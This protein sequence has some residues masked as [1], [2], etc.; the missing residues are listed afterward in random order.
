MDPKKRKRIDESVARWIETDPNMQRLK[1]RIEYYRARIEEK[2]RCEREQG[3]V[4][5]GD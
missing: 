3:S 5:G 2:E 4:E 1:E